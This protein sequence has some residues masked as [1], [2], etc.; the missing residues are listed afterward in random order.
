MNDKPVDVFKKKKDADR[1][2]IM[3]ERAFEEGL[4]NGLLLAKQ[5]PSQVKPLLDER[6]VN[7]ERQAGKSFS[8]E[9]YNAW[10][11]KQG[12]PV[13]DADAVTDNDLPFDSE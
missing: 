12:L 8:F 9:K 5:D 13:E 7:Y 10:R 1:A 2:V 3:L 11:K 6:G 4:I